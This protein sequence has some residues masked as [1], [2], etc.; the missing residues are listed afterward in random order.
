RRLRDS[1]RLSCGLSRRVLQPRR[2][3]K[4]QVLVRTER[5]AGDDPDHKH[6]Q[7]RRWIIRNDTG[8]E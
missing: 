2:N 7:K 4:R 1:S 8:T 5:H 3:R 6:S